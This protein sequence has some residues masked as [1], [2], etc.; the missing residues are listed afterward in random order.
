MYFCIKV[1]Y[2]AIQSQKH[3]DNSWLRQQREDGGRL[4]QGSR[5]K[6]DQAYLWYGMLKFLQRVDREESDRFLFTTLPN[7]I[8]LALCLQETLPPEGVLF[9]EQQKGVLYKNNVT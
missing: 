6:V 5:C 2:E 4:H 3:L 1:I 8:E 7:I 9:S